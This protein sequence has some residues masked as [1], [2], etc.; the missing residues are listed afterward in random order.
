MRM[1]VADALLSDIVRIVKAGVV[2][3]QPDVSD[4]SEACVP[5]FVE[6][7]AFESVGAPCVEASPFVPARSNR[8]AIAILDGL[9]VYRM[10]FRRRS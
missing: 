1:V 10:V 2:L 4:R 3:V 8:E 9:P 5:P 6:H 7:A